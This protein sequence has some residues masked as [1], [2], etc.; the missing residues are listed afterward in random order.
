MNSCQGSSQGHQWPTDFHEAQVRGHFLFS[1]YPFFQQEVLV[2]FLSFCDIIHTLGVPP[3][4][5]PFWFRLPLLCKTSKLWHVWGLGPQ[6]QSSY[7]YTV[8][9]GNF[10][11]TYGFKYCLHI[12][13]PQ[14]CTSG[15]DLA[16]KL[17]SH[18][19]NILPAIFIR[20]STRHLKIK[21][22]TKLKWSQPYIWP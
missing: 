11:G 8:F 2:S 14:M 3:L 22:P 21:M 10:P 17:Q 5:T 12:R 1:F 19:S 15:S 13:E 9:L 6:S 20:K 16:Q 7:I 18:V 4:F